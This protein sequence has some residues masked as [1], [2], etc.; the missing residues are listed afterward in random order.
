MLGHCDVMPSHLDYELIKAM[1]HEGHR[2]HPA[3]DPQEPQGGHLPHHGG[4][5]YEEQRE[6]RHAEN[7]ADV[8]DGSAEPVLS[9][10]GP[11]VKA[12]VV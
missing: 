8:G 3:D 12:E 7:I 4:K 5:R 9:I 2:G 6:R 10:F 1:S 11:I